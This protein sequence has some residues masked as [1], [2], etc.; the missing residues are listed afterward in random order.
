MK[1]IRRIKRINFAAVVAFVAIAAGGWSNA[2]GASP[3]SEGA[4][5]SGGSAKLEWFQEAKFG[6]F[7]HW[8]LYSVPARGEWDQYH[9]KTSREEYAKYAEQFNPT[10]FDAKEW[11]SLAKDAGMKYIVITT[12]HHDGFCMFD[13]KLTKYDIV[14]ATPFGRDP[15]KELADE[16]RKQGMKLCFYYSV[17][18][19]FHPEYPVD[20]T[21]H[22]KEHPNG[23]HTVRNPDADY[24]KYFAYLK[25]Q[26][27]E[28]LTNYGDVGIVWWDWCGSAFAENEVENRK[29]AEDLVKSIHEWQPE[30]LI[31]NRMGGIG[32][33]YGTPEQSIPGSKQNTAF[34]VCM[35]LNGAWGYSKDDHDYKSAETVIRNL[36]DIASK[37]GNYLLN[38]GPTQDGV[39]TS[40]AQVILREVGEW[41]SVNGESIYG[42]QSGGPS[43][44][45]N[46]GIAAVT[47]KPNSLY[48]HLYD[49]PEDN[50][51]YLNDFIGEFDEA[52]LLA[53]PDRKALKVDK[54]SQGLMIHL[55]D[56][57]IDSIDSVIVI[58]YA[59]E[60]IQFQNG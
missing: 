59:G 55:P 3:A 27:K 21:Y 6:M 47:V 57:P 30:T 45:W 51:V 36:V 2:E 24:A 4:T 38:V 32:A 34:E 37:G 42:A 54:H 44:T 25:G 49:W 50:R 46:E 43:V 22:N 19:W 11:V 8:G 17:K 39:I 56:E 7:I 40:E 29:L 53:D 15:M 52:Y 5:N 18:D 28:L 35:T 1:N 33:D 31:N 9:S 60:Y 14:D 41:L 13:S 16:C 58:K 48:L 26:V 20:Y 10:E 23:F 12:K